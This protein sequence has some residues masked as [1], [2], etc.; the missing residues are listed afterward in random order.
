MMLEKVN[1]WEGEATN[2]EE[3]L[4]KPVA[5]LNENSKHFTELEKAQRKVDS[6]I[7][8]CNR[9]LVETEEKENESFKMEA[10]KKDLGEYYDRISNIPVTLQYACTQ[11]QERDEEESSNYSES[12]ERLE[13]TCTKGGVR[14]N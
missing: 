3:K 13:V 14:D 8:A 5:K 9:R 11:S 7:K 1:K 4:S 10:K 6:E 2:K 12:G